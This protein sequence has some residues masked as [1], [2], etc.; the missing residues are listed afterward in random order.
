MRA[1]LA[2]ERMTLKQMGSRVAAIERDLTQPAT[3]QA[4][5]SRKRGAA[6]ELLQIA[7]ELQIREGEQLMLAL[8][9]GVL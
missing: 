3:C 1:E 4:D 5:R 2:V 9:Q 8:S 7:T 6:R